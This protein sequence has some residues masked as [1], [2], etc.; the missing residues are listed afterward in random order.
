MNELDNND[1]RPV[2]VSIQCF[3]YNHEP[4]IRKC[5]DGFIMQ[6]TNFRFEAVVHDDS[7]TDKSPEIIKEYAKK[8]PHIIIPVLES[9][10]LYSRRDGSLE[11]AM[12]PYFRGKYIAICEGDDYWIDP[13]KLQKQFDILENDNDIELCYTRSRVFDNKNQCFQNRINADN[14]PI[15]FEGIL[16]R[17]P[18]MTLTSFFRASSY[19]KFLS[20]E[21]PWGRGW[22]MGDTP[23][24]LWLALKGKVVLLQDI[25][26]VYRIL[27]ES[28]SHSAD[29]QNLFLFNKSTRD[30]RLYFCSKYNREDLCSEVC[31]TYFRSNMSDASRVGNIKYAISN[32]I[33]IKKKNR[34]DYRRL[35]LLLKFFF[36]K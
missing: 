9:E 21:C 33:K 18:T 6:E 13:F 5:L 17:E 25:T 22:L 26:A 12:L 1:T 4:F 7:S 24:F 19:F 15:S 35:L 2:M 36:V 10:N 11:Q 31:D 14:G 3:V 32:F 16:L 29:L 34:R 20:E 28:A 27:G 23:L 8:Y 30:I